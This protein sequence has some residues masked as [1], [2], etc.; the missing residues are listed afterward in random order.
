MGFEHVR[1]GV[2][3]VL[4]A[5]GMAAGA[6][7][8]TSTQA[9][10]ATWCQVFYTETAWATGFAAKVTITNLGDP[11]NSWELRYSYS[12]N[13]RL[14]TGWNGVWSQSGQQITVRN[15]SWNGAVATGK[16][17]EPSAQCLY[18][19]P[20]PHVF[21]VVFSVNGVTCSTVPRP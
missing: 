18:S 16:S 13:E 2:T 17:V 3:A 21:P 12:G 14:V 1:R 15:A 19:S 6:V 5:V 20:P 10:A 9:N 7:P 8:A 4:A 11:W